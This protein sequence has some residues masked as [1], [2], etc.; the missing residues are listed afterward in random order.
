MVIL[1]KP[2]GG[3]SPGRGYV[4][5]LD[6]KLGLLGQGIFGAL[7]AVTARKIKTPS[8]G[9]EWNL[10]DGEQDQAEGDDMTSEADRCVICGLPIV[11]LGSS[12]CAIRSPTGRTDRPNSPAQA[13]A[14]T[15]ATEGNVGRAPTGRQHGRRTAARAAARRRM[16]N[17]SSV[18]A[19]APIEGPHL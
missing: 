4:A 2:V 11:G 10:G 7:A 9:D 16:D 17:C 3:S 12:S 6:H 5:F 13:R 19:T 18:R 8:G 14:A 15:D 1:T